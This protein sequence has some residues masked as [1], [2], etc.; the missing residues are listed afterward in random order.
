MKIFGPVVAVFFFVL[1]LIGSSLVGFTVIEDGETGVRADFGT[2]AEKPVDSGWHVYLRMFTWIE[3][4]DL[5]TQEIKET[6]QV[7]SSEGLISTLDVSIIYNV[8]KENAV[9]VRRMIGRNYRETVVEPYVRESIRNVISGYNTKALYSE[10]SRQEIGEKIG[11]FLKEKLGP[12]GVL[13]QDVLLRDVRLP[14]AF[15]QSIEIK[16]KT[17]QESL[18]KEFELIKAKKDAEIEVARAEGV[19]QSNVIIANS[20]S[21]GYLRYLWIQGLSRNDSQVIYVPTEANLPI[22]EASRT[23]KRSE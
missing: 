21:E 16:L 8:P 22:L 3:K 13:I 9:M 23:S 15:S 10:K 5:K 14:Q 19:A 1:L 2:I 4:W 18:Q 6:A 12:R 20:I 7:P 11:Q 17:E